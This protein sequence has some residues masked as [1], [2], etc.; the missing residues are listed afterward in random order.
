M[1]LTYGIAQTA[2]ELAGILSLQ[3]KN[4]RAVVSNE[5]REKEGFLTVS[6]NLQIL[7]EMNNSCPHVIAKHAN[8]VVGYTL[9]MHPK[10]GDKIPVLRPMFREIEALDEKVEKYI[11]MGQVCIDK[12]YRGLGVFRKLYETMRQQVS[13]SFT[14]IITEVDATNTRSLNAHYAVGFSLL[15]T[16]RSHGQ[17]WHLVA[18]PTT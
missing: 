8:Q 12:D 11:V 14:T 10:F 4:L 3:K 13:S 17:D 15:T 16:H 9:C 2:E 5:D 6:H 18:L 7:T 1:Q